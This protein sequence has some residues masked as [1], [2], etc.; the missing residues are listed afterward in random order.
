M[1]NQTVRTQL[2]LLSTLITLNVADVITTLY[3]FSLG[4][5]EL[6]PLFSE[7]L[8][9]AKILMTIVYT[10]LFTI[11]YKWC[12]KKDVAKG[13]LV[14][15]INLTVLVAIYVVVLVNNFVVIATILGGA[16]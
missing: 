3:G 8:I 16:M 5:A 7:G 1:V 12:Q 15:N 11:A 14:L 13:L 2:T 4:A 9:P 6:N 10:A